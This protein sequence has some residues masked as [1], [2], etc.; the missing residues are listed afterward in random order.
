MYT[1]HSR[2]KVQS[3][4][5]RAAINARGHES[6]FFFFNISVLT[7]TK[8][9][10]V[11]YEWKKLAVIEFSKVRW[12]KGSSHWNYIATCIIHFNK[13]KNLRQI[14]SE[15]L[16]IKISVEN[17]KEKSDYTNYDVARIS[18]FYTT[19]NISIEQISENRV[20]F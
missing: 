17:I 18:Y 15:K 16:G 12:N 10:F 7:E 1:V 13:I 8:K 5:Y 11:K 4:E 20:C 3:I 6:S 14:L 9:K 2:C 19:K